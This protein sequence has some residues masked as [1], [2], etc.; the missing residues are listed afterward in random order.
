VAWNGTIFNLGGSLTDR[1]C[2]RNL[3]VIGRFLGMVTGTTHRTVSAQMRNQLLLQGP[4]RLDKQ[5]LV[6]RLVG[7][8]AVL[9]VWVQALQSTANLPR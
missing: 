7:H 3:P 8:P 1:H 6:D 4:A 9:V 2:I 5:C